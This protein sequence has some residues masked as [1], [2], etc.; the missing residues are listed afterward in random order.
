MPD[1]NYSALFFDAD[2]TLFDYAS[3][4]R[5]ALS[6][7]HERFRLAM[8]LE[9]FV[10]AYRK[11]NGDVWAEFET[12]TI[13]Q[14]TLREERFHRVEAELDPGGFPVTEMSAYYLDRLSR[15]TM[16]IDGALPMLKTLSRHYRMALVTNGIARVQRPRFTDSLLHRFFSVLV[17]SE[18]AGYA[19]PDPRIFESALRILRVAPA[20][21][22]FVGDS[23][24]SDM[25][26]AAAAGMD[27]CWY[28]PADLPKPD[29]HPSR[30]TIRDLAELPVLLEHPSTNT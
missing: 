16:L 5:A 7:T 29:A 4:E 11:H 10:A 21:V 3:G 20:E 13:D 23:I 14:V 22:L 1:R 9:T 18:E 24:S 17:I 15:Q 28:N 27:F 26:A 19:K 8:D 12:G 2:G 6:D 30:W 25:A